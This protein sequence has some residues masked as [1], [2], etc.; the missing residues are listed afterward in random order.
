[1]FLK[2]FYKKFWNILEGLVKIWIEFKEII[3]RK[4][5]VTGVI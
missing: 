4:T 2:V 3:Y 1:M 5:T